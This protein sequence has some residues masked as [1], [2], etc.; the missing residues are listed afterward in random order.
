MCVLG[1]KLRI[2]N[3]IPSLQCV[4]N[5]TLIQMFLFIPE[6]F[7]KMIKSLAEMTKKIEY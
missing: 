1:I 6:Y 3:S 4:L 7:I 5:H 2:R